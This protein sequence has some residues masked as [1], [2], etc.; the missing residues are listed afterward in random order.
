MLT[1]A[2][3]KLLLLIL[4]RETITMVQFYQ[5]KT[6][7]GYLQAINFVSKLNQLVL[8]FPAM[9]EWLNHKFSIKAL[10]L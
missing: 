5:E 7:L 3:E 9:M 10:T 1:E 4:I 8:V 2:S 6:L